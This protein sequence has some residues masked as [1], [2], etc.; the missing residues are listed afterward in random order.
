MIM[1]LWTLHPEY[2]LH[3]GKCKGL[4]LNYIMD[5]A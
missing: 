5:K 2:K 3:A 4:L 1:L